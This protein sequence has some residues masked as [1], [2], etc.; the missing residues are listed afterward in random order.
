M[1]GDGD[2]AM[3]DG[4]AIDL[5]E[6]I[7]ADQRDIIEDVTGKEAS[8]VPQVW[9]L[10]KEVQEYYD[11]GMEVPEDIT[12]LFADDNWG[13]IRRL[14]ALDS[15]REGGYGVYYHFDYVGGP[16]SYKWINVTQNERVW[17]QMHTAHRYGANQLWI[18]NVG[19][20]KPMEFPISFFLDYAWSPD[21]WSAEELPEYSRQWA[22]QQFGPEH[23]PEIA[24]L[25]DTYT[26]Y[27]SRRTPEMLSPD[28]YSLT[29]YRE[30]ER[31]VSSYNALAK[32]A[33]RIYD[34]LPQEYRA[35][36]YQLVLYP[37]AASANLNDLYVTTARNRLYAEQGRAATNALADSVEAMFEYDAELTRR[38]HE[39]IADGKWTGMMSQ[40]HIGDTGNWRAPSENEM[41][42]V[43]TVDL[44]P[45]AEM[46][47]AVEG[48]KQ[49]WPHA[50]TEAVL[51][52]LHQHGR[53]TRTIEVFNRGQEPFEYSVETG[54]SWLEVTPESQQV[55][56]QQELQVT[57][58]WTE[59]PAGRQQVPITIS[60]PNGTS[61][62]VQAEVVVPSESEKIAGFVESNGYVSMDAAHYTNAHNVAPIEWQEIPN[63]GRT[64]SAM[65]T[66]PVT[67]AASDPAKE[68]A[69]LAYKVHLS[70]A[71]SIAIHA[72]LS[73]TLD[74]RDQGGF[75]YG[76]SIDDGP[77][78]VVNMH[79]DSSHAAWQ[80][81]VGNSVN[82]ETSHHAVNEPGQHTVKFWRIDPG[83]VLQKL[84]IDAGGLQPSYL[85]PPESE[86]VSPQGTTEPSVSQADTSP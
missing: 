4:T 29:T 86:Y 47:V 51:P 26:K 65:T 62:T 2:E 34:E 58:D 10:Y 35:A 33:Q 13:N 57:V 44:S 81:W 64:G 32:K 16:N 14:P 52:S 40:A 36:Y 42:D 48:S 18:T 82:V 27:N 76:I 72:H 25:L 5:L 60:G 79:S 56:A 3:T 59:A 20:L 24:D 17:E 12:L 78:Q 39:D 71:D 55:D 8:E 37:I 11:Q 21:Q 66:L 61:V 74:Y 73:P 23:A 53:H 19:D 31:V 70:D 54:A 49:W 84:V 80:Q 50:D 63:L 22:E 77:I 43:E 46:G 15:T 9:A 1:R 75:R 67:A 28:T 30:A 38:Y 6:H 7:M 45:S 41:P 69:H 85:G 83:V 68:S